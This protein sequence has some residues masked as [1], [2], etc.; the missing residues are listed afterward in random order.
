M[1][2]RFDHIRQK[3]RLATVRADLPELVYRWAS[4]R[5]TSECGEDNDPPGCVYRRFARR[6]QPR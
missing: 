5:C 3:A 2:E 4:R 1:T 6:G